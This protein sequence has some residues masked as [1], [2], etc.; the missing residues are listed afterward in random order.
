M[1]ISWN[2]SSDFTDVADALESVTLNAI[3][4]SQTAVSGALRLRI[5]EQEAAASGGRYTRRD[6]KWHLPVSDVASPPEVGATIQDDQSQTWTI[7]RVDH[8]TRSS[9]WRCW[10]RKLAIATT[11]SDRINVQ[12]AAWTKDAHGALSATW[13]NWKTN[14]AARIQPLD[15]EAGVEHDQRILRT[16]HRV[17]LASPADISEKHRLF[18]PATGDTF[19]VLGFQSP[20]RIDELFIVNVAKSPWTLA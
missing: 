2:P 1:T 5:R 10:C 7:L 6:V 12:Q 18:H 17:F 13:S 9:R 3:S 19:H 15:A 16:S 8:D 20:S 14:L 11:L 4:G